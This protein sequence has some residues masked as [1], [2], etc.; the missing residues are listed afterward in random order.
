MCDETFPT[1]EE[2]LVGAKSIVCVKTTFGEFAEGLN[3]DGGRRG[4]PF[5]T[6][7]GDFSL[8]L[9]GVV[10]FPKGQRPVF[11]FEAFGVLKRD[12]C[13]FRYQS[14]MMAAFSSSS[15]CW[16]NDFRW[17]MIHAGL[18]S[19]T[20]YHSY[21]IDELVHKAMC[22][23]VLVP[24][25][26]LRWLPWFDLVLFLSFVVLRGGFPERSKLLGC[27]VTHGGRFAWVARSYG[28]DVEIPPWCV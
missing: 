5:F 7:K 3:L 24:H 1:W 28:A 25:T 26:W 27:C 6:G 16:E 13:L 10:Y 14:T 8:V 19:W 15:Y 17:M 20:D 9:P 18:L 2:S 22:F 23:A 11:Q 12:Q 4:L 21:G